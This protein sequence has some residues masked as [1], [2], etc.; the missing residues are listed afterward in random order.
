M[1]SDIL[2]FNPTLHLLYNNTKNRDDSFLKL[3]HRTSFIN[4][5]VAHRHLKGTLADKIDGVNVK[6]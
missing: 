3:N 2:I 5:V 6:L 1:A 4:L